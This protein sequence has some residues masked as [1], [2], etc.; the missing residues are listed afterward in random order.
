MNSVGYDYDKV[1]AQVGMH[2]YSPA[3]MVFLFILTGFVIAM[4]LVC[5]YLALVYDDIEEAFKDE[6]GDNYQNSKY[7]Y[8]DHYQRYNV[9]A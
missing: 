9:S 6:N 7:D 1:K 2:P 8:G 3:T 5:C 4:C